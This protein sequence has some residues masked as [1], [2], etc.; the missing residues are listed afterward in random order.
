MSRP[1]K[2]AG[3][4]LQRTKRAVY[5]SDAEAAIF[6]RLADEIGVT[7]SEAA[8]LATLSLADELLRRGR[9][10]AFVLEA[11]CEAAR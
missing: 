8:R 5:L 3:S 10:R 4:G 9:C 1:F 11:M 2:Q 6:E 7:F